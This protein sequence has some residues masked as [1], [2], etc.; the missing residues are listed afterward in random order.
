M[1]VPLI[2][3]LQYHLPNTK[4]T[5]IISRPAYDLV[6]GMDNVEFIVIDKPNSLADYFRFKQRL[7]GRRFDVLLAVQSSFRANLLYG[8]IR[9]TR[10]IGYDPLRSK[11]GHSWFINER[12]KP[13]RDHTLDGFLRFADSL[14]IFQHE[15]RW[16][17][18]IDEADYLWVKERIP[19][20]IKGPL[21]LVNPAASKPERSWLIDRY[22]DVIRW[23][24]DHLQAQVVLTGGPG[25][26]DRELGEQISNALPVINLIGKTKPKQLLALIS[27]GDVL[28]CPDTGPS[29]MAAAVGTPVVALHAVTSADVSGP[30]TYRHLSVDCY[31]QAMKTILKKTPE[32]HIWGTHAHGMSTMALVQVEE[33]IAKLKVALAEF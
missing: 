12:I 2:R 22:I 3:T 4:L 25:H 30:Y 14:G 21:V 29:H 15:I 32:T 5:W 13:G 16:D 20:E 27:M 24:Q 28:L 17:L 31:P 33:V 7:W 10:R 9:A 23:V 11:D 1:L 8:C 6:E 19:T 18:P 26:Y